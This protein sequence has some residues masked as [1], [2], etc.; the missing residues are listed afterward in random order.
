MGQVQRKR[1]GGKVDV[2]VKRLK[3]SAEQ[4]MRGEEEKGRMRKKELK[5]DKL[6]KERAVV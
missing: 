4:G 2:H 3:Q 6:I 1:G 5:P